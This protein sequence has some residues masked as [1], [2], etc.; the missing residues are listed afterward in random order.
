MKKILV[1]IFSLIAF[2]MQAQELP[3]DAATKKYTYTETVAVAGQ[4]KAS[5][6]A[7]AYAW[8]T[9]NKYLIKKLDKVNGVFACEYFFKVQYPGATTGLTDKGTVHFT[10]TIACKDGSYTY[11]ITDFNHKGDKGKGDGGPLEAQTAACGKLVLPNHGWA[12]IKEEAPKPMPD[13]IEKMKTA[14]AKK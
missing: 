2:S 7:N 13:F 5:I 6:Y 12:K 10:I 4:K 9:S 3:M 1:F 8:G 14:M 11:T